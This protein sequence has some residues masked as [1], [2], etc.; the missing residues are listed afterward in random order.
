MASTTGVR[1]PGRRRRRAEA[2]ALPAV[3][4]AVVVA[5]FEVAPRIGLL[6]RSAFPPFSEIFAALVDL[7]TTAALWEAVLDTLEAWARAMVIA[8]VIAVP[9]GLAIGASRIGALLS[10]PVIDFL[11]PIPSVALIPILLLLYG[12]RPTL[13]V[14]LAVFG[15][16][17]PLL[18]QAMY[19]DRRRR[20]RGQGHGPGRSG[21]RRWHAPAPDRAAE[22][23]AV[24]ARP[25][26][27]SPRRWR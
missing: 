2:I 20:P 12:T 6:P 1:A 13:K 5:A 10:R 14:T 23:R 4:V 16:M 22:L 27:G 21:C 24:P 19:G 18:F 25:G 26:C 11:R 7:V 17:F 8:T 15:A 3:G 9:L